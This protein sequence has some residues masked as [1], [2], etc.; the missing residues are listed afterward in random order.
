RTDSGR[1]LLHLPCDLRGRGLHDK[2]NELA[3]QVPGVASPP[4]QRNSQAR[5]SAQTV[6]AFKGS[7]LGEK[8][9]TGNIETAR[10][11]CAPCS[12]RFKGR[13]EPE[14]FFIVSLCPLLISHAAI[15]EAAAVVG[16]GT[17]RVEADGLGEIRD[18]LAEAELLEPGEPP[19]GE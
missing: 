14:R 5:A 1:K 3:R 13:V 10:A 9:A 4:R 12:G 8:P 17:C 15:A 11:G 18:G 6:Y 16:E 19:A 2:V 7:T